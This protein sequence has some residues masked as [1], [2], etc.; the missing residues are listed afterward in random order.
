MEVPATR[1]GSEGYEDC[2]G[3]RCHQF[4]AHVLDRAS[5]RDRLS[6]SGSAVLGDGGSSPYNRPVTAVREQ[7]PLVSTPFSS[8]LRVPPP[9]WDQ[10][11]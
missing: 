5:H 1:P 8:R 6:L 9:S 7:T 4:G 3:E 11:A 2:H 10:F